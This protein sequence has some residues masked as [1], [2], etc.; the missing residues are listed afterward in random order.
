MLMNYIEFRNLVWF[1]KRNLITAYSVDTDDDGHRFYEIKSAEQ[2][3]NLTYFCKINSIAD[4]EAVEDFEAYYR[5]LCNLEFVTPGMAQDVQALMLHFLEGI[6]LEMK[7]LNKRVDIM[8]ESGIG[9]DDMD[10]E[11]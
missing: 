8:V 10:G 11:E 6:L 2:Q 3:G 9:H 7:L 1:M 5:H 4:V